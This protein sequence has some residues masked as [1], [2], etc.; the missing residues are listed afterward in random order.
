MGKI[1]F[2]GAPNKATVPVKLPAIGT[3]LN[4][5]TWEEIRAISDAGLASNY[6]TVGDTK[7]IIID[8]TVGNTTFSD[9]SIDVFV[10]GF[11]HNSEVE[12]ANT[13]HFSIGK[14]SGVDI[15]LVDSKYASTSTSTGYF[16]MNT[17]STNS[18]GWASSHMRTTI[19]G[20]DSDPTNPTSST[21]LAALPS[22][23]RAVMK[24]ITKYTDN[25]G[26]GSDTAS[27][28]TATTDYLLLPAE[29]EVFGT[30]SYANSAEQNYQA[31]YDYYSAGNSK[32]RYRHSATTTTGVWRLRSC[33]A[34]ASTSFCHIS[35]SGTISYANAHYSRGIAPIFVV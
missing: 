7:T 21:L 35:D 16:N 1:S 22:D 14:I 13:I 10:L 20:S 11:D 33:R 28:V 4:D 8:G 6:F 23:L 34:T 18:G 26:G 12:G 15:S 31:Q 17:S 2:I 9:L 19:L 3:A 30:R 25:T 24:A 32:K 27:Y 5:C 29:F